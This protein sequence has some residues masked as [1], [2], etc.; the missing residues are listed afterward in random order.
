MSVSCERLLY[1]QI[2]N[3]HIKNACIMN[4]P[5]TFSNSAISHR[6]QL[7]RFLDKC[8]TPRMQPS[9]AAKLPQPSADGSSSC[10]L[11]RS[12][13]SAYGFPFGVAA[14]SPAREGSLFGPQCGTSRTS[15]AS[16]K[17]KVPADNSCLDCSKLALTPTI[18]ATGSVLTITRLK[19]TC[20]TTSKTE[21]TFSERMQPATQRRSVMYET[22]LPLM[23]MQKGLHRRSFTCGLS[24]QDSD[25]TSTTPSRSV[26]ATSPRDSP[27][28]E[29]GRR[30]ARKKVLLT[31][32]TQD[33]DTLR[34]LS[35]AKGASHENY[36]RVLQAEVVKRLL[37]KSSCQAVRPV[38]TKKPKWYDHRP[39]IMINKYYQHNYAGDLKKLGERKIDEMKAG[40][41]TNLAQL[42][43]GSADLTEAVNWRA[44]RRINMAKV[45][46]SRASSADNKLG[47][48][49]SLSQ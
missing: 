26:R 14:P 18:A 15:R 9:S 4:S 13:V 16:A 21:Q 1:K 37:L 5:P 7:I 35:M 17:Y 48:S 10:P 34:L 38:T 6:V 11:E 33:P 46:S 8:S 47:S 30:T 31:S 2:Y 12:P 32:S 19:R 22:K 43:V 49:E 23:L 3:S 45:S 20:K 39:R 44:G 27:L 25:E 41:V 29:T 36:D 24:P 28:L 40:V 42:F